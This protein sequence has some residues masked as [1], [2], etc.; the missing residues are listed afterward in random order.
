MKEEPKVKKK[1]CHWIRLAYV[2][3]RLPLTPV[4]SLGA[5]G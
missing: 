3:I 1:S 5:F 4:W 2:R